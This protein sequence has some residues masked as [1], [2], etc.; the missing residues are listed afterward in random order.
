MKRSPLKRKT[1]LRKVS[2][3]RRKDNAMYTVLR[4]MFLLQRPKCERCLI[5]DSEDV[6]HM[7]GR[8]NSR[9]NDTTYWLPVCRCCHDWIHKHP[10]KA[11]EMGF[12]M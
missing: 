8:H 2:K 7:N 10:A 12:L 4:K 5:S 1:R 6:H 9:L 11:R 3:R